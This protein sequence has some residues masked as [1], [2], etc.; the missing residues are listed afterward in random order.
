LGEEW[1]IDA[2]YLKLREVALGYSFDTEKLGFD[3]IKKLDVSLVGRNLA[4]LFT[5]VDGFDPSETERYWYE[6]GQLPQTR[7]FGFNISLGF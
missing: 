3:F 1:L 7:A 6:G 2:T 4:L 5:Q